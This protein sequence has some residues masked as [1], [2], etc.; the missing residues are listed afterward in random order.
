MSHYF[1]S[2]LV[3]AALSASILMAVGCGRLDESVIG[4]SDDNSPNMGPTDRHLT[5]GEST[6]YNYKPIAG[7]THFRSYVRD[8]E[9]VSVVEQ[10]NS[11]GHID[12]AYLDAELLSVAPDGQR[13]IVSMQRP[14][15]S[16]IAGMFLLFAGKPGTAIQLTNER[17]DWVKAELPPWYIDIPTPRSIVWTSSAVRFTVHNKAYLIDLQTYVLSEE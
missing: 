8:Q 13:A 2:I 9:L 14:P 6:G 4:P 5:P 16:G 11:S 3:A 7:Q 17:H 15:G 10:V 12:F 1:T